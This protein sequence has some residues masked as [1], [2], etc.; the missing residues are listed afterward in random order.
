MI[1]ETSAAAHQHN[2]Q[3]TYSDQRLFDSATHE[4]FAQISCDHNPIHVDAVAAR[5]THAGT[6]VIHG[7]HSLIWALDSFSRSSLDRG[8]IRTLKAQFLRPIYIGD[9]VDLE[10]TLP[11]STTA[12]IRLLVCGDEVLTATLDCTTSTAPPVIPYKSGNSPMPIPSRPHDRGLE[13]MRGLRGSLAFG[14]LIS[15]ITD[16][17]PSA[18]NYFGFDTIAA[19]VSS[20]SLVG[21]VVPG[22]HSMFSGLDVH[23]TNDPSLPDREIQFAVLSV[24][25]RFRLVRIGVRS[26]GLHGTL[27]TISRLPPVKQPNMEAVRSC[28]SPGEF[29]NNIALIVGGS[30]GLGELTAKIIAAGG[31]K[32]VI[33]YASGA[34]DAEEVAREIRAA[35]NSCEIINYDVH[36]AT[37]QQIAGLGVIPTHLYYFATPAIFRRKNGL[38]DEARFREFCG[39]Y[40]N[41]FFATVRACVDLRPQGIKAFFPSSAALDA[42]SAA[43]TEYTMAKA[44]GEILCED[45]QRFIPGL[46]IL[47]RRLPALPTDQT[48]SVVHSKT[49]N[50]IDKLLPIVRE[51]QP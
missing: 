19:L 40:L 45:L 36:A 43:M 11:T 6:R 46:R 1:T 15:D 18:V 35:G 30:R 34:D 50:P 22:L 12:K 8:N 39:F 25:E 42:R 7:I 47:M 41:G 23:F 51:M 3:T 17:F 24:T 48:S 49:L 20:S 31:G 4:Q 2:C 38:F 37:T 13:Q 27:E 14:S 32:V 26:R 5:R 16:L 33:T 10:I 29:R 9:R 21:M 28:V 44:A